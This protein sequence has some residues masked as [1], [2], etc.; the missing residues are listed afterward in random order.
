MFRGGPECTKRTLLTRDERV[1]K[2][3]PRFLQICRQSV[4]NYYAV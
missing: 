2:S 4:G 1:V 3:P